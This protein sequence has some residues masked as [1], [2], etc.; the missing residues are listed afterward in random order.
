M[1]DNLY[2]LRKNLEYIPIQ[3]EDQQLILVRDQLDLTPRGQAI[4]LATFQL[5]ARLPSGSSLE[6]LRK[7]ITWH[8][9]GSEITLEQTNEIAQELDKAFLLESPRYLEARDKVIAAFAAKDVRECAL[10]GQAY[11]DES[12]PLDEFLSSMLQDSTSE[13]TPPPLKGLV[14]PHIDPQ[15][16]ARMYNV[17]YNALRGTSPR[18]VILLGVGHQLTDGLFS[19]TSKDFQTPLGLVR[20]NRALTDMLL[21]SGS[22][23]LSSNDFSHRSEHSIEFQLLFLQHLLKEAEFNIT[24]LLCGSL[25]YGLPEYNRQAFLDATGPLLEP[26]AAALAAPD[27]QCICVAGVDF[28]HIGPKFGHEK[29]GKDLE[30]EAVRHDKALL[31][32]MCAGD[33]D[34][35]W[36]ES[37]SVRD[38]FNVCGFSALA[39]LLEILPRNGASAWRNLGHEIWHEE[40]TAS[41]V[42]FAAAAF[43]E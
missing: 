12:A 41:A 4:P 18:Q 13:V 2:P 29:L 26:L 23:A 32:A 38:Q 28:S 42:S 21:N 7:L 24:P 34:A 27:S 25:I 8:S 37:A 11:P 17:A 20:N 36:Q 9:G 39:T 15:I 3:H 16:G 5:L 33:V 40:P 6:D 22:S 31:D 30:T 43:S 35:F 1:P 14:A 10:A 19:L